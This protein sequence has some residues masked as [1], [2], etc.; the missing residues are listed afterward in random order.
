MAGYSNQTILSLVDLIY[1]A[2]GDPAEWTALLGRLAQLLHGSAGS[3]HSQN[4]NSRDAGVAASWNI[5]PDLI[6]QYVDYYSK[7]NPCF[8]SGK[9]PIRQGSLILPLG[10]LR[11]N[12]LN[13]IF[14]NCT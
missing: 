5:R 13:K 7:L 12:D 4:A 9:E 2:A 1:A 11:W 14:E 10:L 3:L 8:T 6:R